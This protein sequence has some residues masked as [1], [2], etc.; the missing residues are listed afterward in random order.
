MSSSVELR[1]GY[2]PDHLPP[3]AQEVVLGG[4]EPPFANLYW[5]E[6]TPGVYR[7]SV[8]DQEL[9]RS[10]VKYDS[11]TG[12]P[13]FWEPLPGAVS[14]VEDRSLWMTRTEVRCSRCGA[15]LGHVF[16]DGPAPTGERYCMNSA[17]LR[18]ESS[19]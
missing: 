5:N 4:T 14:T 8:C 19:T 15:H 10:D 6:H 3:S 1:S 16:P 7:C 2:S 13:S 9:F 11:G 17:S 12:W 18:L